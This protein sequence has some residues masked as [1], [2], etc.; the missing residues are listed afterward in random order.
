MAKVINFFTQRWVV[1][2]LGLTLFYVRAR[3]LTVE[4]SYQ[5][6]ALRV[7]KLELEDQNFSASKSKN[8][9]NTSKSEMGSEDG[10]D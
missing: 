8:T 1:I 9:P 5:V 10:A 3:F 6:Q 2:L 7:E 4:L